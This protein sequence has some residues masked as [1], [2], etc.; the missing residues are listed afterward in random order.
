MHISFFEEFPTKKNLAKASLIPWDTKLYIAA[1]S[2]REFSNIKTRHTKIYWPT[3]TK[4]EGYWFSAFSNRKALTRKLA[5]IPKG[6]P[7][8]IDAELP[9]TQNPLLYI[10]QI[11]NF[12][13]NKKDLHE[14]IRDRHAYTVEY[15][16]QRTCHNVLFTLLGIHYSPWKYHN[17][18]IK[19]YYTSM[20]KFS[21]AYLQ[22]TFTTNRKQYGK[23]F[24]V[25]LGTLAT[26]VLGNEPRVSITELRR[27]LTIA[28]KARINEVILYRLGGLDTE[29][30]KVLQEFIA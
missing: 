26:G 27:C 12:R 4:E 7:V 14:F 3:L 16:P 17:T 19:M 18:M 22:E 9:T 15:F 20:H 21:D 6:V 24:I 10:T 29:Y 1:K 28:Q 25:A 30:I 8:M 5:E 2:Y 13:K 11:I 23:K